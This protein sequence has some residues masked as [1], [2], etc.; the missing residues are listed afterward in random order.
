MSVIKQLMDFPSI[1]P[2]TIEANEAHQ[3]FGGYPYSFKYFLLCSAEERNAY[4]FG[5]T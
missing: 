4:R 5:T 1:F 3:L 2:H